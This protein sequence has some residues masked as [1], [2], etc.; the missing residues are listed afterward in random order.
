VARPQGRYFVILIVIVLHTAA[1]GDVP[2]QL[3][4]KR[5]PRRV[6]AVG[7]RAILIEST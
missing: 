6:V 2:Q 3:V 7:P 5:A 1:K 4:V